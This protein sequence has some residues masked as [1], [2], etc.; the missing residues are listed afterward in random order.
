MCIIEGID[1]ELADVIFRYG[2]RSVTDLGNA[3]PEELAQVPEVGDV[4]RASAII[5]G[6]Q[7]FLRGDEGEDSKAEA[8]APGDSEVAAE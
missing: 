4:D 5:A 7:A 8:A 3:H 2:W 1:D 6:A